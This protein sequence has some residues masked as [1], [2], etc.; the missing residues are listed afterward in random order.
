M[1]LDIRTQYLTR[2]VDNYMYRDIKARFNVYIFSTRDEKT[3]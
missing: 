2:T 1:F 3:V